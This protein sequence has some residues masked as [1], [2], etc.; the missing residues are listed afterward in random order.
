MCALPHIVSVLE[1]FNS[2]MRDWNDVNS[3]NAFSLQYTRG[4]DILS[5]DQ[6]DFPNAIRIASQ[7]DVAVMIMGINQVFFLFFYFFYF[8]IFLFF[9][10][11]IFLFFYFFKFRYNILPSQ[12]L[13]VSQNKQT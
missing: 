2:S 8:F 1:A 11:F 5:E 9:Y 7:S 10:F 6:S 3:P 12:F 4:C 13:F